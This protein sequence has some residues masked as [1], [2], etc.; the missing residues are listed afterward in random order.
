[1]TRPIEPVPTPSVVSDIAA[2]RPASAVW[3]NELGGV[4]FSVDGG[5]E[6]VK[7]MPL[8]WAHALEAEIHRLGWA[9]AYLTV[10]RVLGAGEGWLHTAGLAG[11]SAVA[12]Q[13]MCD[14]RTATRA[15]GVGLRLMHD[16]LPVDDCPFGPPSWVTDQP[17][18]DRSVVCHG[19]ACAPNTLIDDEGRPCGHVDLGELGVADR[20][21]DLA[22]AEWSLRY[23]YGGDWRDEFFDAYGVAPDQDRMDHYLRQWEDE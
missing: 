10:P 1:V 4:T 20:W 21:A 3:V 6:Y 16:T 8:R 23:N 17:D 15:I 19:D 11:S 9:A 18:V 2:G 14:P 22:V 5:T 7:V 13:W 12:P